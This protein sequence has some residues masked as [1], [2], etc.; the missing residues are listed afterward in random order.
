MRYNP[1]EIS[2]VKP[3]LREGEG[4]RIAAFRMRSSEASAAGHNSR[5][6]SA[7]KGK[8]CVP[9]KF[10]PLSLD[11]CC[12]ALLERL[13]HDGPFG[14]NNQKPCA[15]IHSIAKARAER[16]GGLAV[17]IRAAIYRPPIS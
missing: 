8:S 7:I 3:D 9:T 10:Y 1:R 11:S 13:L 15:S 17:I 16:K 5:E 12:C 14:L 6:Y 4:Q 2:Q